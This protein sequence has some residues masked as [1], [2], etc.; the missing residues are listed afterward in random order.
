[1]S[2]YDKYLKYKNKY[3]ALKQYGSGLNDAQ[4]SSFDR[5]YNEGHLLVIELMY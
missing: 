4:Y 2:Y 5:L 3:L 1:M